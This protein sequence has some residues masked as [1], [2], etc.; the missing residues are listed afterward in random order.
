MFNS[1][2]PSISA[3]PLLP[4]Y[5]QLKTEPV[6]TLE[7]KGIKKPAFQ[8][9]MEDLHDFCKSVREQQG[10]NLFPSKKMV[11]PDFSEDNEGYVK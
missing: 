4:L 10:G 8:K 9:Y 6:S 2:I 7:S 1:S 3:V 11:T 5:H